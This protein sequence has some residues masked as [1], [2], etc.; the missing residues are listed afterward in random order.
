[1]AVLLGVQYNKLDKLIKEIVVTADKGRNSLTQLEKK[2]NTC[3][4]CTDKFELTF[5]IFCDYYFS[6][7]FSSN[8]E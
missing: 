8:N 5:Y 3:F 1:M 7:V 2:V 4:N 6:D